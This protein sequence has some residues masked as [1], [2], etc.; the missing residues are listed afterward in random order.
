Q[1]MFVLQNNEPASL[2]EMGL[3][4][5]PVDHGLVRDSAYFEFSL[6]F[7]ETSQGFRGALNFNT[8]LFRPDTIRRMARHYQTLLSEVIADPDRPLSAVPLVDEDERQTLLFAFNDARLEFQRERCVYDLFESRVQQS[9]DAVAIVDGARHWTYGEL[10]RRANQLARYLQRQGVGPEVRVGICLE[11]SPE[12]VMA[13]LG[14]LKAGGA[15]VP[16]DPAYLQ[17]AEE[18]AKFVLQDAQAAL[19]LTE[20]TLSRAIDVGTAELLILDSDATDSIRSESGDDVDGGATAE[21]LAYVLYT[22]GSTGRPKG[23][24]VTH[25]NLL[26]AYYGWEKE[27]HLLSHVRAHLQMASFG[28]DVFAGDLVRALGS[29]AKLVIC[30]REILLDP[31][32]LLCLMRREQVDG[33]EFVPVVLRTLVQHL[34]DTGQSLDFMRLVVV[35]S[36]AWYVADHQRARRVFG[37]ATRLINSYG[38]TET[39]IDSSFFEGE[40]ESTTSGL[41]PIGRPFPNVR[42][43]VLD[44]GLQPTPIGV[45]GELYIGGEG[46]ARGYVCAD[47]NAARFMPD[48][49]VAE[50]GARMC[51]TGDRARWR[52][53]GQVEFLGRADDQVKIRGFRIEPGEV[54]QV[55]REHPLLAEAAV[56][57]R[58]RGPGEAQLVAYTAAREGGSPTLAEMRHFLRQRLPEYMI[59][60]MFVT[61]AALPLTSSGKVDR[62]ALP[63]PDWSVAQREGEFVAPRTPVE[64]QLASIWSELLSV[65]PVG[66]HDNF[67]DLGGNSLLALRLASRVRNTFS[68]DLPLVTLFTAPI[69][70]ELAE[71]VVALQAAGRLPELPPIQPVARDAPVPLSYGQEALWVI[72]RLQAGPSPYALF[73]AARVK[74]PLNVHALERALNELL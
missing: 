67:F 33:A 52:P 1:V 47:L 69:L 59:P 55:L 45:P 28:F 71:R 15:Y 73:P 25:G 60:T 57:V 8:D 42:L 66:A 21:N 62:R 9:P 51:R 7:E 39:T 68:I 44:D 32:E 38:L 18:R 6:S 70:E 61:L 12:L 48:P 53:D 36:D 35:G 24:M 72:S 14:V 43:Y 22:S 46:V 17:G 11:R 40:V 54:E 26:N 37:P 34:E 5:E 50:T 63:A 16:L 64:Q 65:E 49:F 23:V 74:G 3:E 10:N 27:Y 29:G 4:V 13:V 2:R 56:V 20:S 30:R 19:V 58:E 31:E 41:V